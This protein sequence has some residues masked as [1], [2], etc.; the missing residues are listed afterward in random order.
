MKNPYIRSI[1]TTA[2]TLLAVLSLTPVIAD[3][4]APADNTAKVTAAV[5]GGA[6]PRQLTTYDRQGNV[7][8]TVGE[9]GLYGDPALSPDGMR[10]AASRDGDI[11]V[12]DLSGGT[13]LRV[14]SDAAPRTWSPVWS[15]DGSQI[16]YYS[17]RDQYGGLYRKAS[18]GT[19]TEEL[20]YRQLGVLVMGLSDWSPDGRFLF[21]FVQGDVLYGLPLNGDRKA[22]ELVREEFSA[23]GARLSPDSR[24]LVYSSDE[25]GR[26]EVYVRAF[27]PSSGGFS[28]GGEKSQVSDQ[29]GQPL[30]WRQDGK[31]L[32]YLAKDGGVMAVQVTTTPAF[33]A[34][35]QTLLF[36]APLLEGNRSRPR[37][38]VSRDGQRVVIAVPIPPPERK[39][40][41]V[42]PEILAKYTGTYVT[43]DCGYGWVVTLEGNQL[44]MQADAI[45]GKSLLFA[46]A[47]TAFFFKAFGGD[48]EFVTD[49]Q[50]S[51]T[52]LILYQG[53][54]TGTKAT[55][56]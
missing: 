42:A 14:T 35:E 45:V 52:H 31:E 44:A 19:G 53:S 18:N 47:E 33:K 2:A 48:V 29:G 3:G 36:R 43:D 22:V 40:V 50:G 39:E 5:R 30:G 25:S 4:Q 15:P 6:F 37:A 38:S 8:R 1:A 26:A 13:S 55:R 20:L 28:P 34:G 27:D 24:F 10:L 56:E 23:V 9:P 7:L 11:W 21:F 51:V 17:Y 49:D 54:A 41:T 16:A 12:F 46:E 32:Y